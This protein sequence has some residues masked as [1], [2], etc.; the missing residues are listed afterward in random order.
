[1]NAAPSTVSRY[2]FSCFVSLA[3]CVAALL[4]AG[5]GRATAQSLTSL[6][7]FGGVTPGWRQPGEPLAGDVA[8]TNDGISYLYMQASNNERGLA[9]GNGHLYLV[10]H[11]NVNGSSTNVRVLDALTGADTGG[12]D[13]TGITGGTFAVNAA[14]VGSDGAI[15]VG[16]LTTQSTTSPFK[17][18]KWATEAST[19]VVAYSGDAGLPGSRVGDSIGGIGGGASTRIA[20]GFSNSPSVA[21]NNGYTVVD[22]TAGTA[23]AVSFASTPPN[24]GEMRL[25]LAFSD[26]NHV[27]SKQ[28]ISAGSTTLYYTSYSGSTGTLV[29][30][31]ALTAGSTAEYELAYTV[32]NGV[33]L[34]AA[35][36]AGDSHINVY[37]VADPTT[38]VLLA[39]AAGLAGLP[40]NGNQTGQIAW[41][42][43]TINPD[44]SA[45]QN[46]YGMRTNGGIRAFTFTL[47][48]PSVNGDYNG[49]GVV[50]AAD[51][52]VWKKNFGL[53][54]GATKAQGDGTGDGNVASD[55]YD[56]W[57]TRFGNTTGGS[58]TGG[59]ATTA[60]PEPNT[61]VMLI[62]SLLISASG[63]ARRARS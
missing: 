61:I 10:S 43:A 8:G 57:R 38:P 18:Y 16:N 26:A 36:S 34:L 13:A 23:T 11:A 32:L 1:M 46:L 62:T 54:G 42:A 21:G 19:P 3:T 2:K 14:A 59:L 60:V 37:S 44:G 29:A 25:G 35:Q 48:V 40:A 52:V 51:Y 33:P 39:S 45:T 15:Y 20:S 24:A 28:V 41:G 6:A 4:L 47:P 5:G 58:G 56:Y 53:T 9:Y 31:P 49:N 27:F 12:L 50:D 63:I 17:I 7:S 22:P 55:D 30:S